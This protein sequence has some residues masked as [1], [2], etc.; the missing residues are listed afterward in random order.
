MTLHNSEP[1]H[2]NYSENEISVIIE[3]WRGK[4]GERVSFSKLRFSVDR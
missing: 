1:L 3:E 2:N 4:N